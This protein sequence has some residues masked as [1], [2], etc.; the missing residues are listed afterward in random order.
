MAD[1]KKKK[2]KTDD[3]VKHKV[4]DSKIIKSINWNLLKKDLNHDDRKG[5]YNCNYIL[6]R[7]NIKKVVT[8]FTIDLNSNKIEQTEYNSIKHLV[9]IL[10][11]ID[12]YMLCKK[13]VDPTYLKEQFDNNRYSLL[14][15]SQ[16]TS[17]IPRET[18]QNKLKQLFCGLVF[19]NHKSNKSIYLSLICSKKGLGS[20]LLLLGE[21][22]STKLNYKEIHLKSLEEPYGFYLYKGYKNKK[23]KNTIKF[24]KT[25]FKDI[26]TMILGKIKP[27]NKT[28]NI[29]TGFTPKQTRKLFEKNN[30]N[31]KPVLMDVSGSEENGILMIKSL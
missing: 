20:N 23:G 8:F 14:L 29:K 25:L 27:I 28:G 16:N 9:N 22:I 2:S 11:F 1:S 15:F 4:L 18:T 19:L 10:K 7:I 30:H 26:P 13:S 31:Y 3:N 17:T 6:L 24:G 21:D 12:G 5:N